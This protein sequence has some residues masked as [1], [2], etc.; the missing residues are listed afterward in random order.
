[1]SAQTPT[2]A[3]I[4]VHESG[5]AL[6]SAVA[7]EL[8][9]RLAD[10]QAQGREPRITL[11]GGTIADAVHREV[12]RL[13]ATAE[14][15][16]SRVE[17]WWGDERFVAPDSA[18][19]NARQARAAFLS[20]VGLDPAKVHEMPSTSDVADLE[21]GADAYEAALASLG[22]DA[23]DITML[24]VGPDGHVASLFPGYPQLDVEDRLVVAVT[25]SPKPPPERISLTFPALNRSRA[26]WF[27]VSGAEKAPAVARAL[28]DDA[29]PHH[30]PAAAVHGSDETTWF[31]DRAAA[32]HL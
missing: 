22:E 24:G 18:D 8:L 11:T 7:G 13:T 5:P 15:D 9:V 3:R 16:W 1:M 30:T 6:A 23:F 27:L 31:L 28:S 2:P 29:D 10:V 4:E 20:A 17:I 26:V 21:A 25:D 32:S 12:A 14:V 19:R